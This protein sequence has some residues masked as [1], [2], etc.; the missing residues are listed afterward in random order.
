MRQTTNA[1]TRTDTRRTM[2]ANQNDII[3]N[4]DERPMQRRTIQSND[5]ETRITASNKTKSNNTKTNNIQTNNTKTNT[6][7][8]N[9]D[10]K[11]KRRTNK[12]TSKE[13]QLR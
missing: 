6:T 4:N 8:T 11:F 10:S 1:I 3:T 12:C 9:Y 2:Y 13:E 7:K 5:T